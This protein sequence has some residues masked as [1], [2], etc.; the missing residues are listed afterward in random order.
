MS[1]ASQDSRSSAREAA[2]P[3]PRRWRALAVLGLIQFMLVL[4]ITVV[5]VALPK[6]QH[7]LGF[8]RPGL[9][10]VVNGYVLM[11]GGFLLLGG[12]LADLFGRRR[13]FLAGVI[14]FGVASATCG[15]AVS[16]AMLVSS[17]F[18]QGT[19][20]ALAGPAALAMIPC[21]SPTPASG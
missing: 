20:E 10:W 8:S 15:A 21:C 13:L 11:A 17:R 19:G 7:D 9:A 3:D 4:D 18:V 12:R 6:I 2:G 14:V 16:P 5:T 1:T